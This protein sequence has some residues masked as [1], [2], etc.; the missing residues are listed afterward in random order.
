M[1]FRS[2]NVIAI[3]GDHST[4]SRMKS[5]SWHP[6]PVLIRSDNSFSGLSKRFTE[7]ECL[8]GSL[9]IFE[10][11]HLLTYIFAHAGNLDK[12]GA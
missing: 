8:S 7:S 6:V 12:F 5:H 1:L 3:T 10:A 9:G 11:K 2:F 4:P